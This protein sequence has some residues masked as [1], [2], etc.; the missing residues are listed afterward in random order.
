VADQNENNSKDKTVILVDGDIPRDETSAIKLP[1]SSPQPITLADMAKYL[2]NLTNKQNAYPIKGDTLSVVKLRDANNIPTALVYPPPESDATA[3]TTKEK[4]DAD[5]VNSIAKEMFDDELMQKFRASNTKFH[6][7]LSDIVSSKAGRNAEIEQNPD[8]KQVQKSVD[9]VLGKNRWHP[10]PGKSAFINMGTSASS[11]DKRAIA[12]AQTTFGEYSAAEG[13]IT[14]ED[15]K[16]IGLALM[17]RAT[18][19]LI[20]KNGDPN[21]FANQTG[22]LVPGSAQLL[23]SKVIDR[24][25]MWASDLSKE[26]GAPEGAGAIH[27]PSNLDFAED[28]GS[29]SYGNLNS[30]LEPFGGF[31]PV[32]M[33]ALGAALVIAVKVLSEVFEGIFKALSPPVPGA[34]STAPSQDGEIRELG[35]SHVGESSTLAAFG[36][37][38]TKHN[39]SQAFDRGVNVFFGFKGNF[40]PADVESGAK[41]LLEAPGYYVV[42][43]REMIRSAGKIIEGVVD[44][45]KSGPVGAVQ[46]LLGMVDVIKSS[47]IT[48]Y[49]NIVTRLGDIV[50]TMEDEGILGE[51]ELPSKMK[52][53]TT[54]LLVD[55]PTTRISKS[56][57][58]SDSATLSWRTSAT[59]SFYLLPASI[60]NASDYMPNDANISYQ[61]FTDV[62]ENLQEHM[63]TDSGNPRLSNENVKLIEDEL[64]SEYVPFY[65]HDLRTNEIISFHAF[66]EACTDSFAASYKS[67]NYYGRIDPV[68][69]YERTE[70]TINL[71][72]NVIS[73]NYDD[74]DVMW[75]KINKLTTMLY[76]QWSKGRKL[77]LDKDSKETFIQPFSQIPTSSPLIRLRLGDIF[78]TN[79]SKFALARLFGLGT[80]DFTTEGAQSIAQREQQIKKNYVK[81]N[82]KCAELK[83][84]ILTKSIDSDCG[85]QNGYKAFFLPTQGGLQLKQQVGLPGNDKVAL[86]QITDKRSVTII[87]VVARTQENKKLNITYEIEFEKVPDGFEKGPYIVNYHQLSPDDED[88]KKQVK[89]QG[90]EPPQEVQQSELDAIKNFFDG[91]KNPIVKSFNSVAGRGL[92]GVIT[93][94]SMDMK[95]PTWDTTGIGRRAPQWC[96]ITMTFLPIHDIAPGIDAA[97][98]NR[99][100]IYNVGG[101]VN[102][103]GSDPYNDGANKEMFKEQHTAA[104]KLR[105]KR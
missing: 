58:N 99:A 36:F 82:K 33:L 45:F 53:S 20:G 23:G 52:V 68:R 81:F 9:S 100:P 49:F 46:G 27:N 42:M 76:P 30:F 63:I 93:Q 70:R 105:K 85:Y 80:N 97:G 51:D 54:D 21:S 72:F 31:A 43:I 1:E 77:I 14:H 65:F 67:D 18:G 104:A 12:K 41:R 83:K 64:D 96:Q 95:K 5:V 34:N 37:A 6:D 57:A 84:K 91:E 92:A 71:T 55:N 88:I 75:W 60:V 40:T 103:I 98:F 62:P 50:L 48:A 101:V 17:L 4:L 24:K 15:M 69:I 74:F 56:R 16:K 90:T 32:G 8:A 39:Y 94:M 29:N 28:N 59:P 7:I 73:T 13:D 47:K 11:I 22:A 61:A 10:A 102:N 78:K 87:G 44:A 38:S 19:E 3:F 25:S 2:S 26:Q 35:S 86:K 79:Y 89:A 66:L